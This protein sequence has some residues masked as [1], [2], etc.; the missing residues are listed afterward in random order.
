[1]SMKEEFLLI[2]EMMITQISFIIRYIYMKLVI[3]N[4]I[5]KKILL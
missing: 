2:K 4:R 5:I 1:M 3:Q